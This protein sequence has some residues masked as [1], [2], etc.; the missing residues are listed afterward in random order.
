VPSTQT[1]NT[2]SCKIAG[3]ALVTNCPAADFQNRVCTGC[4]DSTA[5]LAL[6]TTNL[7]TYLGA[8]YND[9]SCSQFIIELVNTMNHFYVRKGIYTSLLTRVG[10]TDPTVTT[11]KGSITTVGTRVNSIKTALSASADMIINP[12]YGIV[13]GMNCA[14][15]G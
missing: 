6:H 3:G 2:I 5:L 13:S 9:A 15:F 7:G 8:R 10:V 14:L 1:P 4:M 11:L 12:T